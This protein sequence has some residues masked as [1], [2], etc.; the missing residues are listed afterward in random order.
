MADE[1][2]PAEPPTYDDAADDGED[3]YD[4]TEYDNYNGQQDKA[5]DEDDDY[6]PSSVNY[7]DNTV[8]STPAQSKPQTPAQS[9][10]IASK[11]QTQVAGF[12]VEESDDEQDTSATPAPSQL[13]GDAGAHSGLGAVAQSEAQDVSLNSAPQ[14]D[15]AAQSSS[16]NG[17]TV[18]VPASTTTSTVAPD[19]TV[20]TPAPA[21]ASEGKTASAVPSAQPTPQ[22]VQQSIAPTPQPPLQRASAPAVQAPPARLP[23]DKVGQLE[24]RIKDD[25]KGD[26]D[27]WYELITHYAAKEQYDNVRNVF[28][29]FQDVFPTA[30]KLWLDRIKFENGLDERGR[31]SQLLQQALSE[32]SIALWK[33]YLDT[34]RRNL[35]LIGDTNGDNR[36]MLLQAF[37]AALQKVGI[38]PDA[39]DLW[40]EYV[41][42]VKDGPGNVGGQGWQDLQK[43]D[44]LRKAYQQATRLP[45]AELVKL[46][47]EY[48]AFEMNIHKQTGRKHIQEQSPHYMQARTARM[49][50]E[51][52]IQRLDRSSLPRLPPIY[53]C[54]GE[55]EFGEQVERWRAWIEWERDEDPLVY[56]GSEDDEWRKRVLYAY[57][58][59]TIYLCFYPEIWFEA[60]SWCFSTGIEAIIAEGEG[61]L[62]R[63][64]A[65]NPESVLLA[66]MKADRV[67]S[68]LESGNTDEVLIR[69][70]ERLNKPYEDVHTALYNLRNKTM[71]KDKAAIAQIQAH[72]ASLPP[73]EEPT[74]AQEDDDEDEAAEKPKTRAEQMKAQI[75]AIKQAS[76]AHLDM[77]KRTISY[78]W[79][80]KMRAFRRVQGQGQP[81][82]RN[83]EPNKWIKGFRGIFGEARPRGPLSSD[84]YIA[85]ALMEWQCYKDGS[86][87]KIFERGMKLFPTDDAFILEYIKHL[88]SIGDITNARVVFEST[89]PKI[90]ATADITPQQKQ[91]RCRPLIGYMHDFES[92][93]GDLA[94]IHKIERRMAEIYPDEPEIARF[95][96]RLELPTFDAINIQLILSP[97][98]A[99]PKPMSSLPPGAAAQ[100][101]MG[102]QLANSI[103]GPSSPK[104]AGAAPEILLGPNGPYVASPKRPLDSDDDG[105]SRKFLR[106]DSPLKGAAGVRLAAT[107]SGTGKGGFATKTFVP[108]NGPAP[109][110]GVAAPPPGLPPMPVG[111]PPLPIAVI[112]MLA[113]LPPTG[114]W[115]GPK[116]S[117]PQLVPMLQHTPIENTRLLFQSGQLRLTK[118]ST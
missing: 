111:P 54:A 62:D 51:Q 67:E 83:A 25:P 63:G 50:L 36:A 76:A 9:D 99:Q 97:S 69:N 45:H 88:I 70:G 29:R 115:Y 52:K 49:Q 7:G 6:D 84:V 91:D 1:Y 2:D 21:S 109:P 41:D 58:Q 73:E 101:I 42:F 80:A 100:H 31:V 19:I 81:P 38:D 65:I 26:T 32:P 116:L 39:G 8:D 30:D 18:P 28:A 27:A 94:Q 71:D 77:M 74:T 20:S 15:T 114:S 43:V 57:R 47:K 103:E 24:D 48:E 118:R 110:A 78:V 87:V 23:H 64:M 4:P 11:P 56:K 117:A 59:A 75:D 98:Q 14:V 37:E 79:V 108:V 102:S 112:T 66:M 5:N 82:K 53:G 104:M 3:N 107:T 68:T 113:S 106:G 85:S 72:F 90:M 17:F 105:P 96:H 13:N 22:P 35:P 46:W 12:I 95:A 86:A 93:Y 33:V 34:A 10:A 40:R 60:A 92:K 16:L 89:I 61:F 55:D 44:L